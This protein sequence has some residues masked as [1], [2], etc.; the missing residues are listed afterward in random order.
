MTYGSYSFAP[1][2]LMSMSK[3]YVKRGDGQDL[4]ELHSIS[5]RGSLISNTGIVDLRTAQDAL[6]SAFDDSGKKFTLICDATTLLECYPRVRRIDIQDGIWVNICD[7]T[8]DLE[9]DEL[10]LG[11][12]NS[13]YISSASEDWQLEIVEDRS[14]Y[15][16]N[17]AYTG[18][19]NTQDTS[20]YALRLTHTVSAQG[21]TH[22]TSTGYRDGWKEAQEWVLPR[23]GYDAQQIQGSGVINMNPNIFSAYNH[24]RNQSINE[25]DG[26]FS[27]TE[28]WIVMNT[29]DGIAG[30]ALE[31]FNI[32]TRISVDNALSSV[33]IDGTIQG[34]ESRVYGSTLGDFSITETKYQAASSYWGTVQSRLYG[35]VNNIVP[36]LNIIPRSTAIGHNLVNGTI[37]Y[38]YEYD[39]RPSNCI[40]GSKTELISVSDQNP[41]DLFASLVI[42][43]KT[44]GPLLQDLSTQTA[45]SRTVNIDVVMELPSGTCPNSVANVTAY[46]A[47]RPTSAVNTIITAFE[48]ELKT[49]YSQVFRSE[50]QVNWILREGRYSRTVSWT[51]GGC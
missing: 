37:N 46:M 5:L 4:N 17:V 27:V 44:N 12:G 8:I 31:D 19:G 48:D 28:S 45:F 15:T 38:G 1:I 32:S 43:G 2:P 25:T 3:E 9:Y 34:L 18:G 13:P 7:F 47:T 50:D 41:T 51:A 33:S 42:L 10:P 21:K 14:Y 40:P 11:S 29:G 30:R 16:W 20:P 6:Y 23:L 26:G 35:R 22:Y 24:I 39:N 49:G 36:N